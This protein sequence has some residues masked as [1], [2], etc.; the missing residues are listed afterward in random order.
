MQ[1]MARCIPATEQVV[2]MSLKLI[3]L[4]QRGNFRLTKFFFSNVKELLCANPAEERTL[5][6]LD[7]D[8][9]PIERSLG[10]QWDTET[11][12]LGVIVSQTATERN[13]DTRRGCLSTLSS[14]FDPLGTIRPVLPSAKRIMQKTW[15]LKLHWDETS[16]EELLKG[17]K[18]WKVELVHLK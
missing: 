4:L 15:K 14:T 17:R 7:L 1:T 5:K 3:K 8:K 10:L 13:D 16:P 9:L 2:E 12:T 18:K 6:N 11:D